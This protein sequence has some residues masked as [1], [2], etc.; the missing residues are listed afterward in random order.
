TGGQEEKAGGAPARAREPEAGKTAAPAKGAAKDSAAKPSKRG[1]EDRGRAEG[2]QKSAKAAPREDAAREGRAAEGDAASEPAEAPERAAA[3]EERPAGEAARARAARS[4]RS[5]GRAA[6]AT[7]EEPSRESRRASVPRSPAAVLPR[8]ATARGR[9]EAPGHGAPTARREPPRVRPVARA[10]GAALRVD[11]EPLAGPGPGA[12]VLR[13]EVEAAAHAVG[14]RPAAPQTT[15]DGR[16]APADRR[17][18]TSAPPGTP[19]VEAEPPPQ[20]EGS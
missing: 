5:E 10:L 1:A 3:G 16:A 15:E 17:T 12:R 19:P 8:A 9:A 14:G 6:T 18:A 4:E 2:A 7:D 11:P 20:I 13:R